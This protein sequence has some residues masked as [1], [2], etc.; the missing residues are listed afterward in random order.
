MYINDDRMGVRHGHIYGGDNNLCGI[1]L[2][3]TVMAEAG[4]EKIC[5]MR[6]RLQ[7]GE[8]PVTE[9]GSVVDTGTSRSSLMDPVRRKRCPKW[10]RC[11]RCSLA[12][13]MTQTLATFLPSP[14]SGRA[15]ALNMSSAESSCPDLLHS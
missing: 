12:G 10:V 9:P 7:L 8:W 11:P 5:Y 3:S 4:L 14:M 13:R 2:A 1:H 15:L 6:I